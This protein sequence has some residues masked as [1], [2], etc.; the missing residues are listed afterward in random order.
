[1]DPQ[2]FIYY[3][4][5]A[6]HLRKCP[7]HFEK[8]YVYKSNKCSGIRVV[9]FCKR[10]GPTN[11]EDPFNKFLKSWIWDQYL[12]ENMKCNFGNMGSVSSNKSHDGQC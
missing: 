8:Y 5:T 7:N 3:R 2:T 11:D 4:I 1:M 9:F 10:L 6:K 12:F